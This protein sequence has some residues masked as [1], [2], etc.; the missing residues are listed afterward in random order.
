MPRESL[1]FHRATRVLPFRVFG[2][3]PRS[4]EDFAS[5]ISGFP[6]AEASLLQNEK[7]KPRPAGGVG[8]R[9]R[10]VA[11]A[12][13]PQRPRGRP[14]RGAEPDLNFSAS[15]ASPEPTAARMRPPPP[16][17]TGAEPPCTRGPGSPPQLVPSL[18]HRPRSAPPAGLFLRL[19]PGRAKGSSAAQRPQLRFP[20][21]HDTLSK[22]RNH[23]RRPLPR[24]LH[25]GEGHSSGFW[26]PS[27]FA[28]GETGS[29]SA[30]S[31]Q[32]IATPGRA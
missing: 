16:T 10:R 30:P 25:P 29:P 15:A 18:P 22:P 24:S 19:R 23:L 1:A 13:D 17:H 20:E 4:R 26:K 8:G 3:R 31:G 11:T 21:G 9:M 5:S 27:P 12:W 28:P 2:R 7:R 14:P 6:C 32:M